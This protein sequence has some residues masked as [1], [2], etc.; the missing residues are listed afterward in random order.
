MIAIIGAGISGLTLAYQLEKAGKSYQLFEASETPGGNIKTLI[1]NGF[2]M[3]SGPNTLLADDQILAFLGEIGLADEI[4]F[5]D[6]K[7]KNRFIY[8]NGKFHGLGSNP[9]SLLFTNLISW[10]SKRVIFSEWTNKS[11]GNENE[12]FAE[13]VRRRFNQEILDWM[14]TPIEYGIHAADPEKLIMEAAFPSLIKIELEFGSILKGLVKSKGASRAKSINFQSG[15]QTLTD[16]L[17]SHSKSLNLGF[18][19]KQVVPSGKEWIVQFENSNQQEIVAEE[20][21]FCIPACRAAAIL[22]A[23]QDLAQELSKIHYNP[24]AMVHR[25]FSENESAFHFHGFGGLIP[26]KA[27]LFSVGSIWSSS[28]FSNRAPNGKRLIAQF[29]GGGLRPEI[30]NLTS[31]EI[32]KSLDEESARLYKL[33]NSEIQNTAIW[34]EAIPQY[35]RDWLLATQ[36]IER[37][38]P[39]GIHFLANWKGGVSVADCIR[40]AFA[41]AEK[42]K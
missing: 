28:V 11:K 35:D 29:A 12:S 22:N 36:Q 13:F 3:D 34:P 20:V 25:S 40:N 37:I 8:R 15:M 38:T 33:S 31:A 17:A 39:N 30:V 14:A 42:L 27:G 4:I 2:L 5:P 24:M 9:S 10:K 16:A 23:S 32:E 26:P 1:K 41:L 6:P 19:V 7:S 21:V 18:S